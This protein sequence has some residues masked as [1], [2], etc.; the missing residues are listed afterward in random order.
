M[1]IEPIVSVMENMCVIEEESR[2]LSG[3]FFW[4]TSTTESTPLT[5][6]KSRSI[7]KEKERVD[8]KRKTQDKKS[9][10]SR[11]IDVKPTF[12]AALNAYSAIKPCES[13]VCAGKVESSGQN[14]TNLVKA[15]FGAK[16]S[17][18]PAKSLR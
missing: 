9:K 13:K 1:G 15:A 4:V 12:F 8:T 16:N 18:V 17:D 11:P 5:P 2:S 10:Q 6:R 7:D 3:T 14:P